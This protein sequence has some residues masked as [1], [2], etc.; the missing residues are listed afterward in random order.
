MAGRWE[1]CAVMLL[2]TKTAIYYILYMDMGRF[3]I[4]AW[5]TVVNHL[6]FQQLS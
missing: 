2:T 4:F 5:E 6:K 3:Q 1:R